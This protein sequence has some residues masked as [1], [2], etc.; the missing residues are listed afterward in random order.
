VGRG[1][2]EFFLLKFRSM[3]LDADR[4]GGGLT[5]KDDPRVTPVGR[6]LRRYKLDEFPQLVNVL[7]GEMGFVGPRPEDP[8]FVERYTAG[9]REALRYRPGITSPASLVF[10]D[11]ENL[12][13]GENHE[14]HYL[15]HLLPK[16]L[17][18]DIEYMSR[19]T[20]LSDLRLILRT[21]MGN[22]R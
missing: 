6:Y 5:Q 13:T 14:E 11:E 19:R 4:K 10:R 21:V 16:K 15:N 8:R 18:M 7:R 9:Q 20:T 17:S 12:L 2:N 1:G 3:S 22:T